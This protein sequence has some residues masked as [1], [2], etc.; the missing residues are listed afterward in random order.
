[1]SEQISRKNMAI[2]I[3]SKQNLICI[4]LC[5]TD[6]SQYKCHSVDKD[7]SYAM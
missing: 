2:Q 6:Y 7:I 4:T 1:M 3:L 5:H